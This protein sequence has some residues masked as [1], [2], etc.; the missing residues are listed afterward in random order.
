[1]A[2]TLEQLYPYIARWV[3]MHGYVQIGHDD[4][5]FDPSYVSALDAGGMVWQDEPQYPTLGDAPRA[6]DDGI[7]DWLREQGFERGK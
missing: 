2:D 3:T 5:S 4:D 1:M 6:L 7:R